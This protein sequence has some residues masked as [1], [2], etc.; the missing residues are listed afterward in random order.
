MLEYLAYE[1]GYYVKMNPAEEYETITNAPQE[2]ERAVLL[3]KRSDALLS[4]DTPSRQEKPL[5]PF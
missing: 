3:G 2:Q 5:I 1:S 4:E